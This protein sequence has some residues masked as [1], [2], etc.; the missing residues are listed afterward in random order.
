MTEQTQV[1]PGYQTT[2]FWMTIATSVTGMLAALGYIEPKQADELIQ[3]VVSVVGGLLT[4][5]SVIVYIRGRIELKKQ[6][7]VSGNELVSLLEGLP[8]SEAQKDKITYV[9]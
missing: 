4:I 8:D 6:S 3:A 5:G 9:K 1:K 2:E 7:M